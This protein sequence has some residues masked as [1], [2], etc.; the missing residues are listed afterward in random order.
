MK[1]ENLILVKKFEALDIDEV[2]KVIDDYRGFY[3]FIEQFRIRNVLYS[4]IS[5]SMYTLFNEDC[6]FDNDPIEIR[7]YYN[8]T[9]YSAAVFRIVGSGVNIIEDC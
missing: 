8:G 7:V 5:C 6:D 9:N 4:M 3:D 1:S 2:E